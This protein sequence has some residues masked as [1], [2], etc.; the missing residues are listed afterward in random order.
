MAPNLAGVMDPKSVA[1]GRITGWMLTKRK[2]PVS[3][4]QEQ[5][6]ER[7]L[8]QDLRLV[9][10]EKRM[11]EK[12]VPV[13]GGRAAKKPRGGGPVS[14]TALVKEDPCTRPMRAGTCDFNVFDPNTFCPL[15]PL[16]KKEHRFRPFPAVLGNG[17]LALVHFPFPTF[18]FPFRA[19]RKPLLMNAL[20]NHLARSIRGR[21]VIRAASSRQRPRTT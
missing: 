13:A 17:A 20:P 9:E 11:R 4:E 15:L 14:L 2:V 12:E 10:H 1:R 19:S 18:T 5:K 3:K 21:H 7:G 6:W 16:T 8:H